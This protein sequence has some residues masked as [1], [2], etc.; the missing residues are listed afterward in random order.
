MSTKWVKVNIPMQVIKEVDAMLKPNGYPSR[1]ALVTDATRRWIEDLQ[2]KVNAQHTLTPAEED[3]LFSWAMNT[4]LTGIE[5]V[6]LPKKLQENAHLKDWAGILEK[7]PDAV[8]YV[9]ALK[10]N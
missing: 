8:A 10:K 5:E 4:N 2:K 1:S 3:R 6:D 7:L 9:L